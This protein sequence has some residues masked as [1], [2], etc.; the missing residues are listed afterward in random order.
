MSSDV[1]TL[2]AELVAAKQAEAHQE[3]PK[4]VEPDPSHVVANAWGAQSTPQFPDYHYDRVS[5]KHFV[6][7]RDAEDEERATAPKPSPIIEDPQA[8]PAQNETTEVTEGT[9]E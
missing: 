1:E 7:V 8:E 3:Y 6:L 9:E 5:Q 4:W 2:E